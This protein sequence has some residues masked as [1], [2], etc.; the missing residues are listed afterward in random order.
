M[1]ALLQTVEF[2]ILAQKISMEMVSNTTVEC[3]AA[4]FVVFKLALNLSYDQD[5]RS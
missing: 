2:L 1:P 5:Q 4:S 3:F